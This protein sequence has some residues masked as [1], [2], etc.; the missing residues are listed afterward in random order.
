MANAIRLQHEI[1]DNVYITTVSHSNRRNL[2]DLGG[3]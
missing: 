2:E 1:P 3:Y